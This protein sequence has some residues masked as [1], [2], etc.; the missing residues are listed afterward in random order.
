MPSIGPKNTIFNRSKIL[1]KRQQHG[2]Y[3]DNNRG[4]RQVSQRWPVSDISRPLLIEELLAQQKRFYQALISFSKHLLRTTG[5]YNTTTFSQKNLGLQS[6][7][8]FSI[9]IQSTRQDPTRRGTGQ[10]PGSLSPPKDTSLVVQPTKHQSK[11]NPTSWPWANPNT[12]SL[13]V[14]ST[15]LEEN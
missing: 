13:L 1:K 5:T 8:A 2:G 14:A 10:A 9:L 4:A 12:P 7:A 6:T 15:P 3:R 11:N